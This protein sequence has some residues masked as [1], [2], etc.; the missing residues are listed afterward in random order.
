MAMQ[1]PHPAF[2]GDPAE[3]FPLRNFPVL[4]I[5]LKDAIFSGKPLALSTC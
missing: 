3:G 2:M 4:P 5:I 1:A